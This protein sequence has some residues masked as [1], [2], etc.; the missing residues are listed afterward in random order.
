VRATEQ[1]ER[2]EK[3]DTQRV[4]GGEEVPL[5]EYLAG[6]LKFSVSLQW[7]TGSGWAHYCG[8]SVAL[9]KNLVVTA[10]HCKPALSDRVV[11]G[12]HDLRTNDGQELGIAEVWRHAQW[13]RPTKH[14]ND[15][16]LI[17]LKHP[18]DVEPVD[19]E[20]FSRHWPTLTGS[21]WGRLGENAPLSPTLQ[22]ADLP[23]LSQSYCHERSANYTPRM[24]CA[25]FVTGGIDLCSGDSGGF[26]GVQLDATR[27][28]LV[29]VTS[30]GAGCARPGNPGYF[31]YL[32]GD[33]AALARWIL[34]CAAEAK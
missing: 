27:W 17:K 1:T 18:A 29:G 22:F 14:N 2:S 25:G 20:T 12:R 5:S 28:L 24:G 7:N 19:I 34:A 11:V 10:A 16:A 15:V 9:R 21:G 30:F 32:A 23:V 8:G 33:D 3:R 26:N 4:V 31:A 6:K 13:N